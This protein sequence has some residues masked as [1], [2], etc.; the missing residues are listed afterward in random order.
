MNKEDILKN[1]LKKLTEEYID[2]NVIKDIDEAIIHYKYDDRI[3]HV[4]VTKKE[5][6]DLITIMVE[7]ME[8]DKE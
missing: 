5:S 1:N 7:K 3:L 6:I 4:A 2:N 8:S